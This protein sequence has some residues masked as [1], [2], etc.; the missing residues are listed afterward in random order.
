MI[1]YKTTNLLNDKVYIGQTVGTLKRR[2]IEHRSSVKRGRGSFFHNVLRKHNKE[3]F[4]WEVI[5]ICPNIDILNAQEMAYIKH[6]KSNVRKYGYN[7]TEGGGGMVGF[8]MSEESKEKMRN[9]HP[10]TSGKN[11]AMYGRRGKDSPN[12]GSI[13]SEERKRKQGET[14]KR[15]WSNLEFRTKMLA[16]YPDRKGKNN[17]NY[18]RKRTNE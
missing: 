13:A 7:L 14:Q 11:N 12:Y 9:S 8:I 3:D 4:K 2:I 5:C 16:S 15:N 6:Y 17:P 10:D 18:G 1:I